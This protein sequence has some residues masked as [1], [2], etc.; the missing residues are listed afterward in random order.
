MVRAPRSASAAYTQGLPLQGAS[1]LWHACDR[2]RNSQ[3][4]SSP[5]ADT[6]DVVDSVNSAH[7]VEYAIEVS[8]V[9]HLEN[10]AA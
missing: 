2:L 9:T 8:G 7:G 10:E 5:V 3:A 6:I 4:H 1:E